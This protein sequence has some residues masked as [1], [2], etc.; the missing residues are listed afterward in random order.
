MFARQRGATFL[1]MLIIG[2][3]LGAGLYMAIRLVPVYFEYMEVVRALEQTAKEH[4]GN[5]TSP[6]EL[7]NSLDRRWTV[8]DIKSISPKQMEIK[9]AGGGYTMRANYRSEVP[10]VANISLVA[11]FDKTVDVRGP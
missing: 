7:R 4:A 2:A 1:G 11:A 3:I 10:F 9:R 8:E 5:P 6:Q